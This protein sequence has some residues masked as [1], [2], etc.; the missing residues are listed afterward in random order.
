MVLSDAPL[1][2]P[3]LLAEFESIV[4]NA[5]AIVSFAGVVRPQSA[6]GVG[7]TGLYLQAYSPLTERGI[8]T[9]LAAARARWPLAGVRVVHRIGVIAAG[10]TI[11]FVAAASAHRRAAFEAADFLMDYLKTD[12]IFWKK[13]MTASGEAWI[14][15]RSQD[16]AD[17]ARWTPKKEARDARHQ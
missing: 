8:E 9:T 10:E 6:A 17:A 12:A 4:Q 16:Y 2:A 3:D 11:V 15:P 13:E 1:S 5:G 7:V 14:E